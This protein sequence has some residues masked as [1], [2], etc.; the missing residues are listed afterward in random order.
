MAGIQSSPHSLND[1]LTTE[2]DELL[3][4]EH[5][6]LSKVSGG[7]RKVSAALLS[8]PSSQASISSQSSINSTASIRFRSLRASEGVFILPELAYSVAGIEFCGF[9]PEV[10][11]VIY[12]RFAT[13]PDPHNNPDDLID[14]MRGHVRTSSSTE[15]PQ[16]IDAFGL[17]S[18]TQ[19]TIMDPHFSDV[20]RTQTLQYWIIDTIE[21]NWTS[22]NT[23][24][25]RLKDIAI[26]TR[27]KKK[28]KP[29]VQQI[30]QPSSSQTSQTATISSKVEGLSLGASFPA[31]HVAVVDKAPPLLD[32]HYTLYK[33]MAV[34]EMQE[35]PV[36]L[37]DGTINYT[38]LRTFAGGDF[39]GRNIA[40]YWTLEEE[41]AEKYRAYAAIRCASSETW[42]VRIELPR[43][44]VDALASKSLFYGHDWKE[45]VWCS[46]KG[47][48]SVPPKYNDYWKPDGADL[49]KGHICCR[50]PAIVPKIKMENVQT[51]ITE[52][53]VMALEDGR[54]STQWAFLDLEVI[55]RVN[56]EMK[57]KI[58]IE[59]FDPLVDTKSS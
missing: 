57:G 32:N 25:Q 53:D 44:F 11:S 46:R 10:A 52:N 9:V 19:Y 50:A 7:K 54:K 49:I 55:A 42:M 40:Y 22:L 56:D 17:S 14:Y 6:I 34:A 31:L 18:A 28:K 45:F 2:E 13:R 48:A 47:L 29:N 43:T 51:Q 1:Q 24:L 41:T 26:C 39:N 37:E 20:F 12:E 8:P 4:E 35:E 3:M 15:T 30:F 59:V 16:S 36:I 23:L 38:A 58:H 21:M 33:G 5:I 27:A